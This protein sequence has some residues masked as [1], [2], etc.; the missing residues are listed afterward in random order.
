MVVKQQTLNKD[1]FCNPILKVS[2]FT[3]NDA[4]NGVYIQSVA[5]KA[6]NRCELTLSS[7]LTNAHDLSV[8]VTEKVINSYNDLVSNKIGYTGIESTELA[9]VRITVNSGLIT[10]HNDHSAFYPETAEIF[11]LTGQRIQQYTLNQ[12]N[13]IT[14]SQ[15]LKAGIYILVLRGGETSLSQKIVVM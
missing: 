6:A 15:P 14:L 11:S 13:E 3:L 5:Y 2:D 9:T 4:P 7:D 12:E 1:Y 10:L 8:T